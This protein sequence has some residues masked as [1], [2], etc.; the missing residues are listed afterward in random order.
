M[1]AL[2]RTISLALIL[3]GFAAASS[4]ARA[5]EGMTLKEAAAKTGILTHMTA[6]T[7][8]AGLD[9]SGDGDIGPLTLLAPTDTAFMT[10]DPDVR[11]KLLHPANVSL[12]TRVLLHHVLLGEY[13][14]KRLLA[15][16]VRSYTVQAVDGTLIDVY[17]GDRGLDVDE[18]RI[19]RGDIV[20]KDGI[21]HLVDRVLI[22]ADL[23]AEI[24]A[25]P[26]PDK[27]AESAP[28]TKPGN[29]ELASTPTETGSVDAQ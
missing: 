19:V 13:P 17:R 9:R 3:V 12:L 4:T 26:M 23:M 10:L 27:I 1:H 15:P 14:T 18:G 20:A 8:L 6:A 16:K 7:K 22:P 5:D 24:A 29:P 2:H 11:A 25:A 28:D 21:I